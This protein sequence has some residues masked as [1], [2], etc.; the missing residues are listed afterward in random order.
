MNL[1]FLKKN[2]KTEQNFF[3]LM[4]ENILKICS[5]QHWFSRLK[6]YLL[7]SLPS[8]RCFLHWMFYY[9]KTVKKDTMKSNDRRHSFLCVVL[10]LLEKRT[11]LMSGKGL[12]SAP[13]TLKKPGHRNSWGLTASSPCQHLLSIKEMWYYE[14]LHCANH[15]YFLDYSLC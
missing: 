1:T 15:L 2:K 7:N 14:R 6:K 12:Q 5:L 8:L 10:T 3:S 9:S 13:A 11:H 4:T